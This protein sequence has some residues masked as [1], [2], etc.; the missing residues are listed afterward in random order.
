M[1]T[2]AVQS[3]GASP[4]PAIHEARAARGAT[5]TGVPPDRTAARVASRVTSA[6]ATRASGCSATSAFATAS[7]IARSPTPGA[8]P[9]TVMAGTRAVN[10]A[11]LGMPN[12]HVP[13]R[14]R[15]TGP[16][17][18]S[19]AAGERSAGPASPVMCAMSAGVMSAATCMVA[20]T[21]CGA[22][23]A[24]TNTRSPA[25]PVTVA[26]SAPSMTVPS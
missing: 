1:V 24:S 10:A 14:G 5:G 22:T 26:F 7:P 3:A 2:A 20:V 11:V 6:R 17:R 9:P 25:S 19:R 12:T 15:T 18:T 13:V 8:N 4:L 21:A 16:E 23:V